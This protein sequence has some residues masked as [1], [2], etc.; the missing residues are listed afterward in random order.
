ME[1]KTGRINRSVL[2]ALAGFAMGISAPLIWILIRLVFFH[3]PGQT[4]PEQVFSDITRDAAS[5][6]L[7]GYMGFGTAVTMSSLGFII[8]SSSDELYK[9]SRELDSLHHEVASQKEIF[10]ERFKVLDSNIKSFHQISSRLQ[11]SLDVD[12]VLSL[13]SEG[14]HEI[15]E[16]EQVNIL[17]ADDTRSHL[18]FFS[19]IGVEGFD[20]AGVTIPLDSRIGI[21][22]KCF[23]ERKMFLV[24]DIAKYPPE[25]R[26][27]PPFDSIKPIRSRSF[28]LCPIVVKGESI[29]LFGIDNK[30]TRRRLN[31]SDLDTIKLFAD[32]VASAITRINLLGAIDTLTRE[33]ENTFSGLLGNRESYSL[34]LD[35]IIS[36]ID[37]LAD[38]T[39]H[40]SSASGSVMASVDETSTA[41]AEISIAIE[42][43]TRNLDSLSDAVD[44]S[45]S[46]MDEISMSLKNVEENTSFSHEVSSL[47]KEE[48][49]KG[50]TVV[51]ETISALDEIRNSV[52]LSYQGIKRLSDNSSR[53]D[54]IVNVINAI[55]RRTNL[56][57]LNASIIAAQAGEYGKSFG[58]VADEIR[59][60][61][62]QTGQST[63]EITGIIDEIMTES[64]FAAESVTA[65]KELVEKGVRLG[66]E[67]GKAL[68]VILDSA[69]RAM[70]MTEKIKSATGEQTISARLVAHS[71]EDVSSMTA[72]IFKASKEQSNA[73]RSIISAIDSIKDTS[74]EMVGATGRQAEDG[75]EIKK[76]VDSFAG[77]VT[78]FFAD[79]EKRKELSEIVMAELEVMKKERQG[80]A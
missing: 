51:E 14:L 80:D 72:Q 24:D 10:Q 32:Q 53:I 60:L 11:K 5:L 66:E 67:T 2:Y 39:V 49:D 21:I 75:A 12:E 47:V 64:R 18:Y 22:F 46:A 30:F 31:E 44:K 27:Q 13:C 71:I 50:K 33:L 59:N 70:E 28:M 45:V 42:Q 43:V 17:L 16:Y 41:V 1:E 62:L 15:L 54:S 40:I 19:S 4:I 61:S 26:V 55:T 3:D 77:M 56:L 9:R 36:A 76:S 79:L 57:A 58:V 29:G 78:T 65:T 6:A 25:Y 73:T 34:N 7:Y 23:D 48:A 20:A 37:S 52:D 68:Q 38:S 74:H 35:N 63:G 8:G 69:Q